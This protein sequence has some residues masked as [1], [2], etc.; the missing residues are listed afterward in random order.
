[1]CSSDLFRQRILKDGDRRLYAIATLLGYTGLRI[2]E[3]L[4][5]KLDDIN[6]ETKELIVRKGKGEKQRIV[7]LNTKIINAMREY[8]KERNVESVYLFLSRESDKVDRSVINKSFKKY[9]KDITPHKLRHFYCTHALESGFSIHEVANLAGHSSIQTTMIYT[10][11][12]RKKMK[13]KAEP[14]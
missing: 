13:D 2:S 9:S 7:Y 10:N 6:L 4:N 1:M 11:P 8:L 5:V 12:S 3:A 14:L